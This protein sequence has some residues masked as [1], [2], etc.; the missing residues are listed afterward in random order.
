MN[1]A[2]VLHCT[3]ECTLCLATHLHPPLPIQDT[4]I[5]KPHVIPSHNK[6][7]VLFGACLGKKL[8]Y[9]KNIKWNTT[10]QALPK[11]LHLLFP[12]TTPVLSQGKTQERIMTTK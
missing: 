5:V 8:A 7:N 12:I 4:G 9:V 11:L 10:K 2:I 1:G 6:G 3:E